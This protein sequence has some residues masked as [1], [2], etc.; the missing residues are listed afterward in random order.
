MDSSTSGAKP[1]IYG[2]S[3]VEVDEYLDYY[4]GRRPEI[5]AEYRRLNSNVPF[6]R[7]SRTRLQN[8]LNFLHAMS[9]VLEPVR[10]PVSRLCLDRKVA[11]LDQKT[12]GKRIEECKS[13][14]YTSWCPLVVERRQDSEL[15]R[16]IDGNHRAGAMKEVL[17][18]TKIEVVFADEIMMDC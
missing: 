3:I 14:E 15:L 13:G 17:P 18:H 1:N 16:V 12:L 2:G 4:V 9:C 10:V 6:L 8:W 11:E 5:L 7:E